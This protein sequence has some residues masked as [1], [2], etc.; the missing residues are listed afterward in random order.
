MLHEIEIKLYY[1]K[2]VYLAKKV[3]Y[4][5]I[6]FIVKIFIVVDVYNF[7]MYI[8]IPDYVRVCQQ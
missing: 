4:C 7:V 2:L 6:S 5:I 1:G 3:N 8:S